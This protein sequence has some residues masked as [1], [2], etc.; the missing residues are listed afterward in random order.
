MRLNVRRERIKLQ[1]KKHLLAL[2]R[3]YEGTL[4][5]YVSYYPRP[6]IAEAISELA[7]EGFLVRHEEQDQATTLELTK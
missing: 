6:E 3:V 7:Q 5:G 2:G 1:I 4:Y